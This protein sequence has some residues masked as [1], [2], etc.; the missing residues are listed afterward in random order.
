MVAQDVDSR[1]FQ[2]ILRIREQIR[3]RIFFCLCVDL[4]LSLSSL[5][6]VGVRERT[7]AYMLACARARACKP[8]E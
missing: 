6:V 5:H 8:Q 7:R 2:H 3:E 4:S 1:H